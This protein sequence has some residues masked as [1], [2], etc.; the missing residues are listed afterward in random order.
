[1]N[2]SIG[3]ALVRSLAYAILVIGVLTTQNLVAATTQ[4]HL[5]ISIYEPDTFNKIYRDK[6]TVII[7]LDGDIDQEAPTRLAQI[8]ANP[9]NHFADVYLNS[10]GG[11]IFAGIEIGNL[12]R[13]YGANTHVGLMSIN[14][15]GDN[16][17][18]FAKHTPGYCYSACAIAFLG[19]VYRFVDKDSRFGVH[20]FYATTGPNASDLASAQVISA[21]IG[22]Y[23][24]EMGVS[25]ELF[26]HM[27]S[28]GPQ[29]MKILSRDELIKTKVANYGRKPSQW[30]IEAVSGGLYLRGT[31]ETVYG[32][33]KMLFVCG[34]ET[35]PALV[36]SYYGGGVE[37]TNQLASGVWYHSLIAGRHE[38]PIQSVEPPATED[39][40]TVHILPLSK[41]I[42][43]A[44]AE[45]SVVGHAMKFR[46]NSPTYLG[47]T[48]DISTKSDRDRVRNFLRNCI[49]NL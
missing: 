7:V 13:R 36:F 14:K 33:G 44:I 4:N 46:E 24:R 18:D 35:T 3:Q 9:R 17:L 37:R 28:A 25:G 19:G 8:L 43:L 27:A 21:R 40:Q 41:E 20:Q 45:A 30:I 11:Y 31:Q 12:L 26:E 2:R 6:K 22:S 38:F 10:P 16:G 15:D 32:S 47:F 5:R 39:G 34:N 42:V 29:D 1:M 23:L 49:K 48:L